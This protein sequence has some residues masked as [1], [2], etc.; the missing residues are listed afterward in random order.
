MAIQIKRIA[1][2]GLLVVSLSAGSAFG[3]TPAEPK[4]VL[5]GINL[6]PIN[7]P[8]GFYNAN[9]PMYLDRGPNNQSVSFSINIPHVR[10][11][12]E[13]YEKLKPALDDL[14]GELKKAAENFHPPR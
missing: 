6:G 9:I 1:Y 12:D 7:P 5:Q 14:S 3:Q 11:L 8:D 4:L 2:L 13:V 10:S